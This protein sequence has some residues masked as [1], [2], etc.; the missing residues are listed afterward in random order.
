MVITSVS[1]AGVTHARKLIRDKAYR[2]QHAQLVVEGE[3]AVRDLPDGVRVSALYVLEEKAEKYSDIAAGH[4][5]V[6]YCTDN[7]MRVLSDTDT[8]SGI[9]AVVDYSPRSIS[10]SGNLVIADGITDPGNLGTIIRTAAACGISD[11]LALECC[12]FTSPKVVRA[13]MG[14]VLKVN[15]QA[16]DR[17]QAEQILQGYKVF[18]LDMHGQNIYNINKADLTDKWA[19]AAGSEAHGLSAEIRKRAD[20]VVSL[21]MSGDMESLNAAVSMS[22]ALYTFIYSVR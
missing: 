1:G 6:F 17:S 7:V 2:L 13:S 15:I 20:K 8:P 3:R 9:A 22:V 16:A 11:V 18:A 10:G 12:D 4:S 19:L 14:G 5:D 21:P